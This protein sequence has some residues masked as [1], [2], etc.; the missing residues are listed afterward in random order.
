MKTQSNYKNLNKKFKLALFCNNLLF[1]NCAFK[2][3]LLFEATLAT[4]LLF[5][6]LLTPILF[7]RYKDNSFKNKIFKS[8]RHGCG[9][10]AEY[11]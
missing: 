6:E 10:Q 4:L 2:L 5:P 7:S 9:E 3:L 8:A 1:I 11:P